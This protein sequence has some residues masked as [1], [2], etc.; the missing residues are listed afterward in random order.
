M[1]WNSFP[2]RAW[3]NA[4]LAALM[5]AHILF[6]A[7]DPKRPATLS[8]NVISGLLRDELGYQGAVLSD[9]LEMR[10]IADHEGPG[11]AA[12][13]S[14]Q[15]GV[16]VLLACGTGDGAAEIADELERARRSRPGF[17]ERFQAAA[18]RGARPGRPLGPSCRAPWARALG[19]RRRSRTLDP[20]SGQ[21]ALARGDRPH[22][23]RH[24]LRG[25]GNA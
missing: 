7:L 22:R 8:E 9:D 6:D 25:P 20:A 15:A 13:L 11:S 17:E 23:G 3:V 21:R 16:D 5:T 2:S 14:V 10:A 19:D 1:R 4:G 18:V 12:V 24:R